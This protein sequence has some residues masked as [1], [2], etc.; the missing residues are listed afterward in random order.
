MDL[1]AGLDLTWTSHRHHVLGT[2]FGTAIAL[3][4]AVEYAFS[5][6]SYYD[7]IVKAIS[8][9]REEQSIYQ[10]SPPDVQLRVRSM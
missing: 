2:E 1:G 7:N 5:M 4:R 8:T 9:T 6:L 3:T 10:S